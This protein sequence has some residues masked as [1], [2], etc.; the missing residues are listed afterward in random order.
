VQ[1]EKFRVCE[2][3]QYKCSKKN[4][5]EKK[6]VG[7]LR[8]GID[9]STEIYEPYGVLFVF[10]VLEFELRALLSRCSTTVSHNPPT[11]ILI[12]FWGGST[13]V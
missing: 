7:I 6:R 4:C 3:L 8:L 5:K 2:T 1:P 12:F 13:G 10:T 9:Q 11:P